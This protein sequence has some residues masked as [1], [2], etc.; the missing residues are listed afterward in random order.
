VDRLLELATWTAAGYHRELRDRSPLSQTD[1]AT[2]CGV[3]QTA[4]ARWERGERRPRGRAAEEY[5]KILA[6]LAEAEAH[7]APADGR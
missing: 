4:V 3:T 5:H 1:V 7:T 6:R 2:A